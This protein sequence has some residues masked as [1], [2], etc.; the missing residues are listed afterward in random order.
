M[1]VCTQVI[2]NFFSDYKFYD[3]FNK[4]AST[5]FNTFEEAILI[6]VD[7]V[8]FVP[9]LDFFDIKRYQE[10]GMYFYRDRKLTNILPDSC[11]KFMRGLEPSI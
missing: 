5:L 10:T 11:R 2:N 6:D 9:P 3:F 4:F 8:P 1:V 7:A